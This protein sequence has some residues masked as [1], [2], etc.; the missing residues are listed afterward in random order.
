VCADLH[1]LQVT[2][3]QLTQW[4]NLSAEVY[5]SHMYADVMNSTQ[6]ARNSVMK[7]ELRS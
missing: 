3:L 1:L 6:P 2:T 5:P 4:V 7:V